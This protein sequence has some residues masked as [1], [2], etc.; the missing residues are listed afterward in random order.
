VPPNVA[1]AVAACLAK[2]P[3]ARPLSASEAL[4]VFETYRTPLSSTS[5]TR[6]RTSPWMWVMAAIA[7]LVGGAGAWWRV[8]GASAADL[9]SIAVLPF[10]VL[11]DTANLYVA[12]GLSAELTT[13][14]TKV[15]GLAVRAYSSSKML[16][17]LEPAAAAKTLGV[18][19]VV[20]ATVRRERDRL[21][22]NASLVRASDAQV[23]WSESF[24]ERDA[25]QFAL[26]GRLAEAI[27]GT[28][29]LR[30][31][32]ETR[33]AVG[34]RTTNDPIAHDLVQRSVFLADQ[35]T[36]E[37]LT[38]AVAMA[39]QAV[40][41]DSNY[42]D[43]WL[44]LA[45]A[46][47]FRADDIDPG[48]RVL[49]PMGR[50][51]DRA[52]AL[53]PRNPEV[54]AATGTLHN[55]YSRDTTL[56]VRELREAIALDST[57]ALALITYAA[58]TYLTDPDSA[59]RI[60]AAAI[61]HNPT[62]TLSLYFT[63]WAPAVFKV[64]PADSARLACTRLRGYVPVLGQ[65]CEAVRL[66][67]AGRRAEGVAAYLA[68]D[69]STF[70]A[71]SFYAW[72]ALSA[73]LLGDS[74]LTRAALNSAERVSATGYVREDAIAVAAARIGDRATALRWMRRGLA[75][76]VSGSFY[77]AGPDFRRFR[78]DPEYDALAAQIY[79]PSAR[80]R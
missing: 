30:L 14:L 48:V 79:Q 21:Y 54:I 74:T 12:D 18:R 62:T 51:L 32:P 20:M 49:E 44:A 10:D 66:Q 67:V 63:L 23:L 24:T 59:G 6:T 25:D 8:R 71:P 52:V 47:M 5:R 27:T 50:A 46:W 7:L 61:R 17:G 80:T 16:R 4:A 36:P 73:S 53:D 31:S 19:S 77:F 76:H 37:A 34:R 29:R 42:V 28:L 68:V 41:R 55:W 11:S 40:A 33:Q 43:A 75:S 78:G 38:Q 72:R 65:Y 22:V 35:L 45:R 69:T 9:R 26:Q 70:P 64:L 39:E 3:E 13:R 56:G 1:S 57:N 58:H 2:Q 60:T 15:P